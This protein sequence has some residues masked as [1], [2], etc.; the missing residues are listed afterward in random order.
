MKRLF[1]FTYAVVK[2]S[3]VLFAL[4][5]LLFASGPLAVAAPQGTNPDR[6]FN[7]RNFGALGDGQTLDTGA[8]QAAIEAASQTGGGVVKLPAGTYLSGSLWL[9]SRVELNLESGATLLGS[10]SGAHYQKD[11][12]FA[13]LLAEGQHHIALSGNGTVDG[14]GR[15]LA[16]DVMQRV[17][18]GELGPERFDEGPRPL[19]I[20]FRNCRRVKVSGLTL[21]NSSCWTQNYVNCE[22]LAIEGITVRSTVCWNNDGLDLY[23]CRRVR[24]SNCDIDSADDGI[25]LKSG[26]TGNGC[27]DV[28]ISKCR[29]RSSASALKL[30]TASS[31]GFRKI[32]AH[33][34][35]I[36]DTYR[37]AVALESVD[38]GVLE[39]VLVENIRATNTG[40]AIFLRLGHRSAGPIGALRNVVIRDVKV[41]VPAGKPDVGYPIEGPP[42]K[43]PHNVFPSS[44]VG[45]PGHPVSNV[46]LENIEIFYPGGAKHL[47]TDLR[48]SAL[49]AV[50]VAAQQN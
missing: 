2:G 44:V 34:L 4:A 32:R 28:E 38:G 35:S 22:G 6:V 42:V 41:Q 47:I 46:L 25:C 5:I 8:I 30:G 24:V 43:G 11:R 37:S 29:I 40:N 18:R 12:W 23:D 1:Q 27:Y 7:V 31:Q 45:L 48:L 20:Q 14:Q 10:T 13:L 15:A 3:R 49:E 26:P 50:P 9:K 19:L 33:H 21:R 17:A 36:Y 16:Q 39:D